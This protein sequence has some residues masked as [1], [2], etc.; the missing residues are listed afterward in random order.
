VSVSPSSEGRRRLKSAAIYGILRDRIVNLQLPPGSLIQ[1]EI[2]TQEFDV[3]SA[4]LNEALRRLRDERLVIIAPQHGSFVAPIRLADVREGMFVRRTVEPAVARLAARNVTNELIDA[5][6][7]NIAGQRCAARDRDTAKLYELDEE[8]HGLFLTHCGFDHTGQFLYGFSAHLM[9][10][11]NL[12]LE[13]AER[14]DDTVA[15]HA[16]I[17][18]AVRSKDPAWVASEMESHLAAAYAALARVIRLRQHAF[19]DGEEEFAPVA[20]DEPD[21]AVGTSLAG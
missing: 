15:E 9:R 17:V 6:E 19:K 4:P 14:I 10:A 1:K 8:F 5:L 12:S 16:R 2:L 11:R 18:H 3:S 7:R 20:D 13:H 21:D